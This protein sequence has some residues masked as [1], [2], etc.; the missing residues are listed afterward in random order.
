MKTLKPSYLYFLEM[1]FDDFK[2]GKNEG[3]YFSKN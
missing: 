3:M 1:H 2:K